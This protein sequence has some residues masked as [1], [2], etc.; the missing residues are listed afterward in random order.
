[1]SASDASD[2]NAV[3][4]VKSIVILPPA[5]SK[6][7]NKPAGVALART[8]TFAEFIAEPTSD[9]LLSELTAIAFPFT[10]NDVSVGLWLKSNFKN[11]VVDVVAVTP[12]CAET[13]LI[14]A[15]FA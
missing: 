4:D 1:M 9:I 7:F 15:A 5:E 8:P 14:A 6:S 12:L 3:G 11:I 10:S 13:A 2:T